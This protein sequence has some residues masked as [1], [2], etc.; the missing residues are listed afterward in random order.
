MGLVDRIRNENRERVFKELL[1]K[2]YSELKNFDILYNTM[3]EFLLIDIKR[4]V[5]EGNINK[6]E[7]TLFSY[8]EKNKDINVMFIAGE[9]YT[10]LMDMSDEELKKNDFSR[11]EINAGLEEIRKI[12]N[13]KILTL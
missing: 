5:I 9:F 6:A 11:E 1:G 4:L 12:F 3:E 7:D 2:K 10:M 8:I 13:A